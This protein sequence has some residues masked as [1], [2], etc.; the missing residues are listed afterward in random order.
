MWFELFKIL[1]VLIGVVGLIFLL[2]YVLRRIG[3]ASG[4]GDRS[5]KGWRLLAAKS[6]G[7]KKQVCLL[8]VGNSI[9]VIGVSEKSITR[10]KEVD[11]P[12][13]CEL[14]IEMTSKGNRPLPS[15][16]DV[17]RRAQS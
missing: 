7:P 17:L 10:L 3:L 14:L 11:D 12:R 6:L 8:E 9:L 5:T 1:A 4:G 2:A 16:R 15:F 13:E